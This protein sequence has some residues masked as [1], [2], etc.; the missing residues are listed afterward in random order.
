ML[1]LPARLPTIFLLSLAALLLPAA[2]VSAEGPVNEMCPVL[3]EE[4]VD[5]GLTL[6]YGGQEIGFCCEEC[7]YLFRENPERYLDQ[8]STIAASAVRTVERGEPESEVALADYLEWVVLV[9]ALL[10][11]LLAGLRGTPAWRRLALASAGAGLLFVAGVSAWKAETYRQERDEV[12]RELKMARWKELIHNNTY[13]DF[14][15]PPRPIRPPVPPRL[16]A[17]FYRGNDER[18]DRLFNGGNY[19]TSY[20][21][22]AILGAEGRPLEHGQDVGGENLALRFQIRRGPHTPDFFWSQEILGDIF[23]TAEADPFLGFRG[24]IPD[25]VGLTTVAP[26]ERWESIFPL[27]RVRSRG[28]QEIETV[29]YVAD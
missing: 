23:L 29:V 10:A 25:R 8:L 28:E 24:P 7:R 19:L 9:L 16:E 11:A 20:L 17:T 22:V 14:G 27:G 18:S 1:A 4:K 2:H 6:H 13:Y 12:E 3:T 15:D 26:M 5:P 21:D